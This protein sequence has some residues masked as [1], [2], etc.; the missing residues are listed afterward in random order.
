MAITDIS[1]VTQAELG[2][3][4]QRARERVGMS[5]R[6]F[7]QEVGKDQR[8]ISEYEN[9]IRRIPAIDL[10]HFAHV[11]GMPITYFYEGDFH[12]NEL[13]Q[14]LL[15]EF[16]TLPTEE[17]KRTIIET[18]RLLITAIKRHSSEN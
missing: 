11:L 1:L 17:D 12:T 5:Q 7:A 9:G 13:D 14:V 2:Q 18:T 8:A 6:D 15:Q 16:H 10:A 3:R 4:I